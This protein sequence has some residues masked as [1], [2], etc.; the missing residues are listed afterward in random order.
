MAR[1]VIFAHWNKSVF[2]D[3]EWLDQALRKDVHD[4]V[5]AVRAV[6]EFDPEGVLPLLRLQNVTSV[7]RMENEALEI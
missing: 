1:P 7:R 2:V 5:I 3:V 4:V 6:V